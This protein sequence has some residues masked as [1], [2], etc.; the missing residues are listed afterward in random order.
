VEKASGKTGEKIWVEA[1][2][3]DDSAAD[4]WAPAPTKRETAK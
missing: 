4:R 2:A 3:S 1:K